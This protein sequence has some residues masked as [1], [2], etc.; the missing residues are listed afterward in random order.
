MHNFI[1]C[2]LHNV[3][4]SFILLVLL[5]FTQYIHS[6]FVV[7]TSSGIVDG[8]KKNRVLNWDDIPYAKPPVGELRWKAPRKINNPKELIL[9]KS[10]VPL[11]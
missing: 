2:L 4:I 7:E 10:I 1:L 5:S 3:F 8:Y 9:P 11:K 6:D